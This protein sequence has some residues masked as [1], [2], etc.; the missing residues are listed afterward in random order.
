MKNSI[1]TRVT[2]RQVVTTLAFLAIAG[3]SACSGSRNTARSAQ[4]D[5]Y[6]SSSDA[7]AERQASQR[8]SAAPD[9][10][11]PANSGNDVS[12]QGAAGNSQQGAS[13]VTQV[14][15]NYYGDSFDYDDYY[16][17]SYSS[18]IR[19]FHQPFNG[20]GYYDPIYT[21][22]YYYDY[23]PLFWGNSIYL[24]YN[25][26][27]PT[28]INYVSWNSGWGWGA[29]WGGGWYRPWYRP[30][31]YSNSWYYG[32]VWGGWWNDPW[33]YNSWGWGGYGWGSPFGFRPS[34]GWGCGWGNPYWAGYAHGFNNGYWNGYYNGL[35]RGAWDNYYYNSLDPNTYYY[36]HR[37]SSSVTGSGARNSFASNFEQVQAVDQGR[38]N[39]FTPTAAGGANGGLQT[40]GRPSDMNRTIT[41]PGGN[42]N[43]HSGRPDPG[44]GTV[45]PGSQV[46]NN[47]DVN[48]P[49]STQAGNV[50][51]G[52]Q[53]RPGGIRDGNVQSNPTQTY[54]TPAQVR[55]RG[56]V[57]SSGA[58]VN[59]RPV[60]PEWVRPST[61]VNPSTNDQA[62]PGSVSP[63][64][65]RPSPDVYTRPQVPTNS[66]YNVRPGGQ[67][68]P[69]RPVNNNYQERPSN[70]YSPRPQERPNPS[71]SRPAQ[72]DD[73][74]SRPSRQERPSQNYST[75]RTDYQSSPAPSGNYRPSNRS[76]YQQSRPGSQYSA[77]SNSRPSNDYNRPAPSS[78]PS[79]D[80]PRPSGGRSFSTPP[81]GG[82]S[83][84]STVAPPSRS[85][86][87]GGGFG[88]G[89][90]GGSSSGGSRGGSVGGGRR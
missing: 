2:S 43:I 41:A 53:Q 58:G 12:N 84:G 70:N 46:V 5:V 57:Q 64:Y 62:R 21:N 50:N 24:G 23:D 10:T 54:T 77:P 56:N 80:S 14:T 71:G 44:S 1:I 47:P 74:Y 45:R 25:W 87:S 9:Y 6:F 39:R 7:R 3:L 8:S 38:Y 81:S 27:A 61:P 63:G 28:T 40:T 66:N 85:A 42:G 11:P 13:G 51:N 75:P 86:P 19:R 69:E 65:S 49:G 82:R 4:D 79:Y 73:Y 16:D 20:F 36:G 72:A 26:W 30:W 22:V 78:R 88:G 35:Y 18:R 34:F 76:D 37:N 15:N 83:G 55:D 29:G 31:I 89:S 17:Y 60:S 32:S 68:Q 52:V 33:A 59:N 48:R 90:R 67:T